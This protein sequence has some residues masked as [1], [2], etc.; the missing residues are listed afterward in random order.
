MK[1]DT[2]K[3]MIQDTWYVITEYLKDKTVA[4]PAHFEITPHLEAETAYNFIFW[5]GFIMRPIFWAWIKK[6]L[7]GGFATSL[8]IILIMAMKLLLVSILVLNSS[9]SMK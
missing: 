7:T 9:S 8:N 6:R 3:K 2:Y 4:M 5:D 1:V